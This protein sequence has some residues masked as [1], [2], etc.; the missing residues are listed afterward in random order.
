MN[1]DERKLAT[2]LGQAKLLL[3]RYEHEAKGLN[4]AVAL[5]LESVCELLQIAIDTLGLK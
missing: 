2:E 3:R 5:V 4:K 1:K